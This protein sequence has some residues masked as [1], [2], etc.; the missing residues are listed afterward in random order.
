MKVLIIA[1]DVGSEKMGMLFRPYYIA[2]GLKKRGHEVEIISASYSRVRKTNPKVKNDLEKHLIE[3]IPYHWLK[4]LRFSGNSIRRAIGMALFSA[5][6]W[7][8]APYFARIFKADAVIASSPHPLI[9]WGA[10]RISKLT[11]GNFFFEVRD[12]WPL[13]LNELGGMSTKHP[14]YLLCQAAEDYA[15][16]NAKKVISLLPYAFEHM[17]TRGLKKENFICIPNGLDELEVK[18]ALSPEI[19]K[20]ILDFKK[21]HDTLVCYAG[22]HSLANSL[23]SLIY[24]FSLLKE[25]KNLGLVLIGDG[26]EKE[27]LL[28]KSQNLNL[29]NVLF[30]DPISKKQ[31]PTLLDMIDIAY[32]GLKKTPLFKHGISPNKLIDY[33]ASGK[34]ILYAIDTDRDPVQESQCGIKVK[35]DNPESIKE[36]ILSLHKLNRSELTEMGEKGRAWVMSNLRYSVLL[37][38]YEKEIL[39]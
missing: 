10:N 7:W 39:K 17:Q 12:I 18:E 24:A 4:S 20:K 33:M 30:L 32:I 36:G 9:A 19:A 13:S 37:N 29:T 2:Q 34:A 3:G 23:E 11:Q 8:Y 16:R 38:Q 6:L 14:F 1:H 25:E 35:S 21:N 26:S 5:K 27:K 28:Y 22:A 15:Y 31:I